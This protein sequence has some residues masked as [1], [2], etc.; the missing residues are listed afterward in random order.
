MY[1]T[2]Y[3][4]KE[5]EEV[6]I[7]KYF[8]QIISSGDHLVR[9]P[10]CEL[11]KL[12]LKKFAIMG[13]DESDICYIGNDYYFDIATPIKLGM[14]CVHLNSELIRHDDYLEIN[15]YLQLIEEFDKY[16]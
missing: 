5:L 14:M 2:L 8:K 1:S 7:K 6:G 13:I 16:E 10:S 4:E 15:N 9:K 3:I 12:Y 11:F